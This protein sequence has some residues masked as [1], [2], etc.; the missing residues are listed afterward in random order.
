MNIGVQNLFF[1]SALIV[2]FLEKYEHR[3]AKSFFQFRFIKQGNS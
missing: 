3:S 1:N 2:K